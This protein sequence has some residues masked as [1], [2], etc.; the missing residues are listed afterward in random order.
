MSY[1]EI[2]L[3]YLE[4]K[5]QATAEPGAAAETRA[6]SSCGSPDCAGCYDVGDGK[7]I[8]PPKCG[9][10]Y[11]DWLKRWEPRGRTQ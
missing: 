2:A 9:H 8:H 11:S 1:L 5:R 3:A 7:K 4:Q 10:G 6:S